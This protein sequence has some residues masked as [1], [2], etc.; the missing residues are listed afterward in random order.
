MNLSLS[1][2][3]EWI[4]KAELLNGIAQQVL[5]VVPPNTTTATASGGKRHATVVLRLVL[6][7]VKVEVHLRLLLLNS[8]SR[9][10]AIVAVLST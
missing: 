6:T 9:A 10:L 2:L 4:L 5:M 1:R 3:E 8:L 7:A